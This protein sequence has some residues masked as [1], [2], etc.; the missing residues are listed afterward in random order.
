MSDV[1]GPRTFGERE[2]MIFLG[3]EIH[4]QR[5]YAEKVAQQIDAEVSK[6]IDNAY[7]HA[8][9]LIDKSRDKLEKIVAVLLEKETLEQEEF[10]AILA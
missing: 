5:D 10:E 9:S 7:E 1:L 8:Q 6:F 2:E 3:R 4:D